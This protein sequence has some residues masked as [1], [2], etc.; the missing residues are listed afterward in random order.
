MTIETD[1]MRLQFLKEFGVTDCIYTDISA[2][3]TAK[4]T[5]LLLK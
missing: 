1:D 4:I 2:V 5:T 3:T